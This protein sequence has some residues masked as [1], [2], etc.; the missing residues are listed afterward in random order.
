[1]ELEPDKDLK[2]NKIIIIFKSNCK[3]P[4]SINY[5]T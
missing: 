1:M 5:G 2:E 4:G 3:Y